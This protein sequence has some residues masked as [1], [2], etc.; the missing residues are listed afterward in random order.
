MLRFLIMC[1]FVGF[2]LTI[3][4]AAGAQSIDK[5][6]RCH[7]AS[8]K[9]AKMEVCNAVATSCRDK[10]SKKFTKCDAPNAEPVPKSSSK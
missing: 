5:N 4:G 6:G 1:G 3:S 7:D 8:G 10:T 9:F 2:G